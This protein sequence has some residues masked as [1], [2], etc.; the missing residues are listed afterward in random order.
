VWLL[1]ILLGYL[2]LAL[3]LESSHVAK[4]GRASLVIGKQ[5]P[6][7]QSRRGVQGVTGAEMAGTE[8]AEVTGKIQWSFYKPLFRLDV[9]ILKTT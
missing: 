7:G 9:I 8:V 5:R 4:K 6:R 3:K 2:S 1:S